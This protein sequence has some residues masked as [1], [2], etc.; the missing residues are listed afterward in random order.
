MSRRVF[1]GLIGGVAISQPRLLA[2]Q[3]LDRRRRICV[4]LDFAPEHPEAPVRLAAF[5]AALRDAGLNPGRN[6]S[7]D[8][9]WG[10]TDPQRMRKDAAE[11][12][13]LTPNVML[14]GATPTMAAVRR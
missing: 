7:I 5:E 1:I 13:A 4:L 11:L 12:L 3:Q 14:I 8:Y 6:L 10:T 2:A 9:R